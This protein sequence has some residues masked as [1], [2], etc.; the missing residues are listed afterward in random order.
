[1]GYMS[2]NLCH[3]SFIARAEGVNR[4]RDLYFMFWMTRP[5]RT[6]P[7]TCAIQPGCRPHELGLTLID[8]VSCPAPLGGRGLRHATGFRSNAVDAVQRLATQKSISQSA[9]QAVTAGLLICFLA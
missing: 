6:K 2:S 5:D 7:F 3:D 1:M 4:S 9:M 8:S